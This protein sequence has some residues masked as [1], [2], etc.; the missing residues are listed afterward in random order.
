MISHHDIE[1]RS[2]IL[3]REI[4]KRIDAD[5]ERRGLLDARQ[6]CRRWLQQAPCSDLEQ[7]AV[8]LEKPW[9]EVRRILLDPC[10]NSRQL[11]QS[12]PFCGILTPRERW[13]IYRRSRPHDQNP[14]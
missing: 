6:R 13:A 7:W 5:P 8:I 4:A 9:T 11:R 12:N 10:E 1:E 2:L 3:A 14:A